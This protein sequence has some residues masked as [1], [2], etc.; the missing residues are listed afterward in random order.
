MSRILASFGIDL[1]ATLAFVAI[2]MS[3]HDSS[4]A[5]YPATAAPFVLAL[6]AGWVVW[7]FLGRGTSPARILAG[8]V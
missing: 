4:F 3:T 6:V 8:L 1:A 2:G 7:L 5:D